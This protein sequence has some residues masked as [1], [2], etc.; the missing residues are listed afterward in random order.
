[1]ADVWMTSYRR[2]LVR[3]V[4]P[5]VNGDVQAGLAVDTYVQLTWRRAT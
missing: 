3:L 5:Y 2:P 1:M 4:L